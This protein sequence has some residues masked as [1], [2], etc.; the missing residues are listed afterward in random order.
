MSYREPF[1]EGDL[2]SRVDALRLE[3]DNLA[4][5]LAVTLAQ[6]KAA[7]SRPWSWWR[8]LVGVCVLPAASVLLALAVVLSK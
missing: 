5:S 6:A 3:R 7:T 1:R 2:E 4:R 8:F